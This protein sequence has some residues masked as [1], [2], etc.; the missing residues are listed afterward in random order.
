MPENDEPQLVSGAHA[1]IFAST[2]MRHVILEVSSPKIETILVRLGEV[3]ARGLIGQL[4]SA[5]DMM[6]AVRPPDR[7]PAEPA[8]AQ[9]GKCSHGRVAGSRA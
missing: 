4:Q 2:D 5:V 3:N 7:R 9:S 1:R 8:P 6:R